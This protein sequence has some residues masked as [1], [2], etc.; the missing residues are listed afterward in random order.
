VLEVK[1]VWI[2]DP[3]DPNS[4]REGQVQTDRVDTIPRYLP[5]HMPAGIALGYRTGYGELIPTPDK[6]YILDI[7]MVHMPDDAMESP[8]D[9]P[10]VDPRWQT[11]L[12]FGAAMYAM[13]GSEAEH[14]DPGR[15]QSVE[16]TWREVLH[17]AYVETKQ[18]EWNSGSV[19][20][21]GN[22]FW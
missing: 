22:G 4:T 18:L 19:K 11:F 2:T 13:K 9:E 10:S 21:S 1:R 16:M 15:F 14:F 8:Q 6:A 20:F 5:N 12:P 7:S 3:G 17:D